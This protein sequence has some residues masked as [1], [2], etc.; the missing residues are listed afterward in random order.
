[1]QPRGEESSRINGL[2]LSPEDLPVESES[3]ELVLTPR[4]KD[5]E[6]SLA[7]ARIQRCASAALRVEMSLPSASQPSRLQPG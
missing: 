4:A 2:A 5:Y 7:S 6:G 3:A 1:M